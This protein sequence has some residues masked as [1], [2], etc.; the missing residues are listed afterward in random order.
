VI[1][2]RTVVRWW[3]SPLPT[4]CC[5]VI[6]VKRASRRRVRQHGLVEQRSCGPA[7]QTALSRW[8]GA[9]PLQLPAGGRAHGRLQRPRMAS[10]V[11]A[12]ACTPYGVQAPRYCLAPVLRTLG[13]GRRRTVPRLSPMTPVPCL[14]RRHGADLCYTEMLFADR[15]V[16]DAEYCCPPANAHSLLTSHSA[17][18][19]T[20]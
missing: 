16:T 6:F 17:L 11:Q 1:W 7:S 14:C 19:P 18:L 3:Q 9:A 10:A 4:R 5:W 12:S 2:L 20:Y 15:F 13:A 8:E